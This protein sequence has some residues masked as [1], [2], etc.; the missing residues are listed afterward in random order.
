MCS[1]KYSMLKC[2]TSSMILLLGI[3]YSRH[4]LICNVNRSAAMWVISG[5]RC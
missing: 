1:T 2:Q 5:K 4:G 3:K